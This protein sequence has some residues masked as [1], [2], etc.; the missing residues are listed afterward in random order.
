[1]YK[2]KECMVAQ[3]QKNKTIQNMKTIKLSID[4]CLFELTTNKKILGKEL[5]ISEN[6][7]KVIH[8]G[9]EKQ[10]PI[11]KIGCCTISTNYEAPI[12]EYEFSCEY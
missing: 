11:E 3:T 7:V 4:E 2:Y 5:T 12:K 6:S 10:Y 9:K 1:M 8:N